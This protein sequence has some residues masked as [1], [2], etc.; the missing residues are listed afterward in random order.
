M[1]AATARLIEDWLA[2]ID[3]GR[4]PFADAVNNAKVIELTSAVFA[5]RMRRAW[6]TVPLEDR[7]HPPA[8]YV[9]VWPCEIHLAAELRGN[10]VSKF[11]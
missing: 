7:L 9:G 6:L 4:E 8:A 10:I 11:N 3:D 1:G 5:A 2:A